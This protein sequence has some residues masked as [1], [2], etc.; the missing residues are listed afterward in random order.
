MCHVSHFGDPIYGG[1]VKANTVTLTECPGTNT[2]ITLKYIQ[3]IIHV[4]RGFC[5]CDDL[6]CGI[7]QFPKPSGYLY[8]WKVSLCFLGAVVVKISNKITTVIFAKKNNALRKY[9]RNKKR[10][11]SKL[12]NNALNT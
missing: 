1:P 11:C 4:V 6:D 5:G 2:C 7:T 10:A 3:L 12:I 9:H 8:D